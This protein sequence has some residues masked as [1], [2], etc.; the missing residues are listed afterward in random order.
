[1]LTPL[2]TCG[3]HCS[4]LAQTS[5]DKPENYFTMS[6]T[7]VD[8]AGATKLT[9]TQEDP[10]HEAGEDGDNGADGDN[11]EDGDNEGEAMNRCCPR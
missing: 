2:P 11:G 3:T 9:I 8:E 1:V 7:L 6:Y 10:C 4:A 5:K